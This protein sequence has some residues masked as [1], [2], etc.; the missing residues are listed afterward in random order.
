MLAG[1]IQ[2]LLPIVSSLAFHPYPLLKRQRT[3]PKIPLRFGIVEILVLV[4]PQDLLRFDGE[5]DAYPLEESQEGD[6]RLRSLVHAHPHQT[7][8]E[9]PA[10][11]ETRDLP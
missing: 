9:Q 6:D 8:C 2:Y 7:T 5:R 10:V 3:E 4:Q 11:E 1:I